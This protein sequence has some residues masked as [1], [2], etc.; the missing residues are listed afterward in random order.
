VGGIALLARDRLT[1]RGARAVWRRDETCRVG[2]WRRG[3]KL[4]HGHV[5]TEHLLLGLLIQAGSAAAEAL[6]ASGVSLA[7]GRE[8]VIE[9]LASRATAPAPGAGDQ[10][11]L[12]DRASRA[13]DR[14][15]RL[16]LRMGSEVVGS[17]HVLLSVLDVEGTAGQVLRGLSVDPSVVREAL[18]APTALSPEQSSDQSSPEDHPHRRLATCQI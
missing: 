7:P 14:A 1:S 11:P 2:G 4:G 6:H 12:T 18:M 5:G 9:A 13:L 16:S 15:T 8:K 10:V 17:D 3:P